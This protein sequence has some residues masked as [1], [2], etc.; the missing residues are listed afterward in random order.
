M[1][2]ELADFLRSAART[3][4]L[5][6]SEAV[7]REVHVEQPVP[8]GTTFALVDVAEFCAVNLTN[9]I[10]LF[11]VKPVIFG[12][13]PLAQMKGY[14]LLAARPAAFHWENGIPITPDQIHGH[15]VVPFNDPRLAELRAE[16]PHVWAWGETF[17]KVEI[18]P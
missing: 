7:Y 17:E 8:N 15:I 12:T 6:G 18:E 16:W 10:H 5:R 11:E 4:S 2:R 1:Q 13:A 9:I 14:L 3:I